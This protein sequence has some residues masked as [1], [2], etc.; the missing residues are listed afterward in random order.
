MVRGAELGLRAE[1]RRVSQ[2]ERLMGQPQLPLRPFL[3]A[4][5]ATAKKIIADSDEAVR[6]LPFG[7]SAQQVAQARATQAARSAHDVVAHANSRDPLIKHR[8]RGANLKPDQSA[9]AGGERRHFETSLFHVSADGGRYISEK[10]FSR[11]SF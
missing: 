1:V 6:A 11:F 7:S 4:A 2:A 8:P 9:I 3:E 10:N 5:E